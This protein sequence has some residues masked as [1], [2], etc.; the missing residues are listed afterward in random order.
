MENIRR[1]GAREVRVIPDLHDVHVPCK[2]TLGPYPGA[3]QWK[4]YFVMLHK[5]HLIR[6]K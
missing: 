3:I 4:S 2:L 1:K 5:P 6:I